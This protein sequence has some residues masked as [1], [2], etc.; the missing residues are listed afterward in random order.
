MYK[1]INEVNMI[2][3]EMIKIN[4][5][6]SDAFYKI[7]I[8]SFFNEFLIKLNNKPLDAITYFDIDSYL[9]SLKCS[10]AQKANIYSALKR[11]FEHTYLKGISKEIM[12][13]VTK[14]KYEKKKKEMLSEHEYIKLKKFIVSSK[15]TIEERLIL[16][17]FLFT[18]LSRKYIINLR[19]SDFK[20]IDGV[21]KLIIWN[22]DKEIELPLKAELQL[23]INEYLLNLPSG[24]ELD[25][26]VKMN[27]NKVSTYIKEITKEKLSIKCT[28]TK[29]S[30]TFIAK[31]LEN[32]N[33][34]Y[35]VSKLVLE[36]I[37][38]IEKH[39][40]NNNNLEKK[41]TSILNSF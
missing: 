17:L 10:D 32:G 18:G 23:I 5:I 40:V 37:A 33:Y 13:Q 34:V 15:N 14:P 22:E 39:I 26:V 36:S 30:N 16:G 38:T 25:K 4:E 6:K 29:L 9:E 35:E 19:N 3:D 24:S 8:T 27:E 11:F 2:I 28:P 31:A 21:Y 7:R 41:Q 12:S 1:Y 20:F